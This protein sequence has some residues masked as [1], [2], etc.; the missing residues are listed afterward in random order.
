MVRNPLRPS[1]NICLVNN[2]PSIGNRVMKFKIYPD[3]QKHLKLTK[4]HQLDLL[5]W[6]FTS[7][8]NVSGH[9]WLEQHGQN[10]HDYDLEA[11]MYLLRFSLLFSFF[12]RSSYYFMNYIQMETEGCLNEWSSSEFTYKHWDSKH[13]FIES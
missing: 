5:G 6:N 9:I 11:L 7:L 2:Q 12:G 4:W 10:Q 13:I 8:E 1:V 3:V